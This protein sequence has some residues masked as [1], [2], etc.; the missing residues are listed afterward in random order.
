[1]TQLS[2]GITAAR[3]ARRLGRFGRRPSDQGSRSPSAI[4]D[5]GYSEIALP[6]D[7]GRPQPEIV[8]LAEGGGLRGT[9]L[10]IGCGSGE[11]VLFLRASGLEATG[12]DLSAKAIEIA[13]RKAS[14][15]GLDAQ[16]V[17]G[18]ALRLGT[19]E[20][21]YDTILD[22]G[23]FHLFARQERSKLASSVAGALKPGGSYV[24]LTVSSENPPGPWPRGETAEE[25]T[26]VFQPG[27][28]L[29]FIRPA[30]FDTVF[31][32]AA[33]SDG[34]SAWLASFHRSARA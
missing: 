6:W 19:L 26:D 14:E 25:I 31:E 33:A 29:D 32:E 17:V 34:L 21:T 27:W 20:K 5:H 16:F 12:L 1:M 22:C 8:R 24:I 13:H 3:L 9:I 30:R 2:I 15:R 18:D 28:I 7:I 10:D 11:N 4:F 23:L